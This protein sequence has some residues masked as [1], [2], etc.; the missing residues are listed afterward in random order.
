MGFCLLNN[1]AL[2]A[3]Y[4]LQVRGASR[5]AIVDIDLHHGNGTQDIFWARGDVLFVSTHQSPLYP[6]TGW[7]DE[8]GV[9]KGQGTTVNLP[10]PPH[11]GDDAMAAALEFV[12]LPVL[13]RF[14]PEMVLVSAGFDPHWRDPLGNLLVSGEGYRNTVAALANWADNHCGGK[15]ALLLEGGYDL[16]AAGVCAQAAVA[17]LLGE[18]WKDPLGKATIQE[19]DRWRLV[20]KKA[21][22]IW[23]L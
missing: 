6:G 4:L 18:P 1:I 10:L 5:L 22:E 21:R 16:D 19:D 20:L 3:E 9:G 13:D 7:L 14:R 11:S 23:D 2:A 15:I 8:T 17:A 12:I